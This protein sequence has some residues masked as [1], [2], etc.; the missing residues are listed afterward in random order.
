MKRMRI[1]PLNIIAALL[2]TGMLWLVITDEID[3]STI[4][5]FLLFLLVIV[6]ADQFFRLL[7]RRLTQIWITE[8]VFIGIVGVVIWAIRTW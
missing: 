7:V 4:G 8:G 2:M 1:T 6:L 5:W 3:F